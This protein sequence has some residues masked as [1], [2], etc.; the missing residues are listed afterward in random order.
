MQEKR[1][2]IDRNKRVFGLT[3]VLCFLILAVLSTGCFAEDSTTTD[4]SDSETPEKPFEI[5]YRASDGKEFSDMME[6][7]SYAT[8]SNMPVSWQELQTTIVDGVST[9][10][11][12]N[13]SIETLQYEGEIYAS[14]VSF[15]Y[16]NRFR[17]LQTVKEQLRGVPLTAYSEG[18]TNT[19]ASVPNYDSTYG[20]YDSAYGNY[21][22]DPNSYETGGSNTAPY[23][24]GYAPAYSTDPNYGYSSPMNSSIYRGQAQYG[25]PGT[26][27]YSLWGHGLGGTA[28]I[29]Q[30]GDSL[31][32][33]TDQ[34]GGL[35]GLDLFGCTD[36]RSGL[37]YSYEQNKIKNAPTYFGSV[38]STDH[39]LGLYHH[40][41]DEVI[42]NILTITGG[43]SNY[44]T[45]REVLESAATQ[46][47]NSKN[48]YYSASAGY[49]RGANF[50]FGDA[51]T[52]SPYGGIDYTW[53]KRTRAD[54]ANYNN[55]IF[56]LSAHGKNYNSLRSTLGAR[57]SLNMFPGNQEIHLIL[58]GNWSHEFLNS[59]NGKTTMNF[60]NGGSDFII[61]GNT[62]G[63]DWGL[64]GGGVEWIPIPALVIY[65]NY[66]YMKNKYLSG[67]L[68][69]AG[70][71]F[72]W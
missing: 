72:R 65:G 61:Y 25:D 16:M 29:K 62:M 9:D 42:Y 20:N 56:A 13:K 43:Y 41:G 24:P 7:M 46:V 71:R 30:H 69:Y 36:C 53:L 3:E 33:K 54:E 57:A 34:M 10:S 8:P 48:K 32:Y 38:K 27:I 5:V 11:Y 67:Q 19:N 45:T 59:I 1:S 17:T 66:D 14:S 31:G 47:Y 21:N 40:F 23:G 63:R 70:V 44:K 4:P 50:H 68:G 60:I 39:L 15:F 35:V 55:S 37:F 18:N 58:H 28:T 49:E 2:K 12:I 6:A 22:V 51:F 64:V 26:L 52:I